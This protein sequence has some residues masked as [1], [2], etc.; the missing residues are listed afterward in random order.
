MANTKYR[1]EANE[2]TLGV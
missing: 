1:Y 2:S